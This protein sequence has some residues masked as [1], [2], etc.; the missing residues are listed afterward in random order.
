MEKLT[1]KTFD[2][3][4]QPI[5]RLGFTIEKFEKE[6]R[7]ALQIWNDPK[8]AY[9]AKAT[10][11]SLIKS[12][13]NVA[14]TGLTLNPVAKE[15]F[16]I[17]RYSS[18]L[19]QVECHLEPSYIGL[20]KLITD[21]GSVTSIQTNIV[22]ENDHFEMTLGSRTQVIHTPALKNRGEIVGVYSVANLKSGEQQIEYMTIEEV[23]EIRD[24]SE[25][26]Q[27]WKKD[28]TKH[29]IWNDWYG[30]MVRKTCLKRITKYLPRSEQA[31]KLDNAIELMNQDFI[32]SGSQIALAQ[33]LIYTSTLIEPTK[34]QLERELS[35]CN[36]FQLN[37][38]ISYLNEHQPNAITDVGAG[39]QGE[40]HK[41][42]DLIMQTDK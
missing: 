36:V 40:I 24:I 39:S 13:I 7:F 8:N 35:T 16:L 29:S 33:H 42:L 1:L 2:E 32:P 38:M 26:Y 27:A 4:K 10:K 17:P 18:Y 14:Q 12:L 21:T 25:S 41:Q 3:I 11:E 31:E 9:L 34:E 37:K 28:N 30:E 20:F 5:I 23:N 19:K 6:A 15:A 22:Y